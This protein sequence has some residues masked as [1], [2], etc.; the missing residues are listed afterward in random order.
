VQAFSSCCHV[1]ALQCEEEFIFS[2]FCFLRALAEDAGVVDLD[3][4]TGS[5]WHMSSTLNWWVV[6]FFRVVPARNVY[7]KVLLAGRRNE[8]GGRGRPCVSSF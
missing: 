6:F 8:E 1:L 5:V 3:F 4:G 7:I 2:L